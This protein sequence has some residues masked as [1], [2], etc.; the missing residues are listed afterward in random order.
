MGIKFVEGVLLIN[1]LANKL[2]GEPKKV[3]RS[4]RAITLT[5]V[6]SKWYASCIITILL[7]GQFQLSWK[8]SPGHNDRRCL[9]SWSTSSHS[10]EASGKAASQLRDCDRRC[11][12]SCRQ[13]WKNTGEEKNW[14]PF[15]IWKDIEHTRCAV[16]CG[17]TTFG[18]CPI[19]R[20]TWRD[21]IQEAE[22]WDWHQSRQIGGGQKFSF[23]REEQSF[24]LHQNRMPEIPFC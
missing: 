16:F 2:D 19:S 10:I 6:L 17:L 15:Q 22:K 18:S 23:R 8:K 24:N 13:T 21:L 20:V 1:V 3:N 9:N 4:F 11:P 12:S 7:G 14:A 5:S